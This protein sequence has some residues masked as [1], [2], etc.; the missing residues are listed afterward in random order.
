MATPSER[1]RP[2]D[3]AFP[4]S[5]PLIEYGAG[6]I[7]RK[8]DKAGDI[9]FQNRRIRL[10]KPFR[11]EWSRF[12]RPPRTAP[13]ASI[14]ARIPSPRSIFARLLPQAVGLWTSRQPPV[15]VKKP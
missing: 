5:L 2:S 8:V 3:R 10:G 14:F 4:E 15:P 1:Y 6:D 13:S 12:A 11:G 9:S 7:V